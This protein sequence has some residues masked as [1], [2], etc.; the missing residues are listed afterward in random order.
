VELLDVRGLTNLTALD[1][2]TLPIV[3]ERDII[4]IH[5][6]AE[7]PKLEHISV[8]P[9]Q[10]KL[11]NLKN[12]LDDLDKQQLSEKLKK[13]IVNAQVVNVATMTPLLR[14]ITSP[15]L[16]EVRLTYILCHHSSMRHTKDE[17]GISCEF[18]SWCLDC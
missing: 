9:T 13:L 18:L 16:Y 12:V 8:N 1:I 10:L 14:A 11:E 15:A 2:A 5:V 3:R 7:L 6:L 17:S 4:P